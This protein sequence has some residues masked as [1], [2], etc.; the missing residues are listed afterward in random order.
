MISDFMKPIHN[1]LFR[2]VS[3]WM[4][5]SNIVAKKIVFLGTKGN[6]Y[7][8]IMISKHGMYLKIYF[9]K[10]AREYADTNVVKF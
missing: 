5:V 3:I 6:A 9:I 2:I 10:I 7:K 4:Y 1:G 8:K